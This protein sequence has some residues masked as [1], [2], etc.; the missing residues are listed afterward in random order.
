MPVGLQVAILHCITQGLF[1]SIAIDEVKQFEQ[2]LLITS[3]KNTQILFPSYS[4]MEMF[5]QY[6]RKIISAAQEILPLPEVKEQI[7]DPDNNTVEHDTVEASTHDES[8]VK[9]I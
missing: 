8:V 4:K 6:I 9:E 2:R 7:I 5:R 1:D 3:H